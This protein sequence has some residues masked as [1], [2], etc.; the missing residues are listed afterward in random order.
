MHY[1]KK[2]YQNNKTV[3]INLKETQNP[4]ISPSNSPRNIPSPKTSN[5]RHSTTSTII[6]TK[7]MSITIPSNNLNNSTSTPSSPSI[8]PSQ[9]QL[10]SDLSPNANVFKSTNFNT[11]HN[12]NY[13]ASFNTTRSMPNVPTMKQIPMIQF[14]SY[15]D[16]VKIW[17]FT[18][19][20]KMFR[21]NVIWNTNYYIA[22]TQQQLHYNLIN[23]YKYFPL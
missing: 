1:G 9:N 8:S 7:P 14:V 5:H 11:K 22:T 21:L 23:S 4:N 10:Y 3:I 17:D 2:N 19:S 6:T 18:E 13:N 20:L 12:A 15:D 16:Y